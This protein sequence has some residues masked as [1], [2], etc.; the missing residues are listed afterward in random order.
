MDKEK[1]QRGN[2]LVEA[3]K[4]VKEFLK[5]FPEDSCEIERCQIRVLYNF[6]P[7][8]EKSATILASF[9]PAAFLNLRAMAKAELERY[10]ME[11]EEL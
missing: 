5:A 9:I 7:N 11:F 2:E 1:L 10:E 6:S 3:I 4:E 8:K